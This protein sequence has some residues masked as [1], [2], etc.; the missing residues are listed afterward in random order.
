MSAEHRNPESPNGRFAGSIEVSAALDE[1]VQL[2]RLQSAAHTDVN[3]FR[4]LQTTAAD[5]D[6]HEAR[7]E[8]HSAQGVL[9]RWA[10]MAAHL[11]VRTVDLARIENQ[12]D[13][14][15][16]RT[17]ETEIG[18][19]ATELLENEQSD[20]LINRRSPEAKLQ[21]VIDPVTVSGSGLVAV[22]RKRLMFATRPQP[23][24]FVD[25]RQRSYWDGNAMVRQQNTLR[26]ADAHVEVDK[27]SDF[28]LDIE[29][30]RDVD[31]QAAQMVA[32]IADQQWALE[33]TN[34]EVQQLPAAIERAIN[35]RHYS[36]TPAVTTYFADRKY[37][38]VRDAELAESDLA[39]V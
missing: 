30:F 19:L 3:L 36:L 35:E 26:T 38:D 17:T 24:Q 31:E 9:A 34:Q 7:R 22:R 28:V 39:S 33:V 15:A 20:G 27:A 1:L 23:V 11:D 10:L 8:L 6:R 12:G 29:R 5:L 21:I 4:D 16:T 25:V 18:G 2:T 37:R 13:W 32:F 14:E